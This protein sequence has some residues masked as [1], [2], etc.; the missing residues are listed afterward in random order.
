MINKEEVEMVINI[1]E[2]IL[3]IIVSIDHDA[4]NNSVFIAVNKTIGVLHKIGL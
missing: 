1:L 2:S 4:E 3:K